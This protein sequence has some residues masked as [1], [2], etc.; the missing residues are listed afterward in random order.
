MTDVRLP[1]SGN[2]RMWFVPT[3]GFSN[4]LSPTAAEINAGLDISDAV[5]WNDLDFGIQASNQNDDPAITAKSNVQTRGAS[6]YGGSISFYYPAAFND[7]S[8]K[9]SNVFEALKTPG[10]QGYIVIRIDGEELTTTASTTSN[11]GTIANVNDLVHVFRVQT[12]GWTNVVT[13]ED[14]F[15]FTISFL[16]KGQSSVYTV[17]RTTVATVVVAPATATVA[18]GAKQALTATVL[19]RDYT[20]GVKWTSSDVTKATVSANG[21]VS[22]SASGAVTITATFVETGA[23]ATSAIS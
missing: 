20:R 1:A 7:T 22:R 18:T 8:N 5:S 17:V 15:R 2:I 9:Y 11:P 6:Q 16:S 10:T 12:G 14:A 19:T 4:W 23:T 21:V 13:G 3:N